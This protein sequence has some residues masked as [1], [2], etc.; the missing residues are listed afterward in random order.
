VTRLV[1]GKALR[2][3]A[4]LFIVSF[5]LA[6]LLDLAP[7]DPAVSLLGDEAT[8]AQ[9]DK[10]HEDLRLD[11]PFYTR[12]WDWISDVVRGDFGTSY[13]TKEHVTTMILDRIPV[14]LE[15]VTL[16][17]LLALAIAIPVG[18]YTAYRADGRFDRGW[19]L[20]SSGMISI[21]PFVTALVLVYVFAL[22][23][24]DS[25]LRLPATG[26]A[27][28]GDSVPN[29]LW[30]VT[31]PVVTLAVVEIPAFSRLLRAD[32]IATLQE[33]YILAARAKGV[34][35]RR[36]L[37]RHALRPSSFSL[38]TLAGLS[39]ARLIGGAVVV[40]TLFAVPGLGQLII[41]AVYDRDILVLQGVVMFI[42]IVY[43]VVN[44]LL[45][46]MYVWLDPRARAGGLQP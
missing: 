16:A 31:L 40:E 8:P 45:D 43:I 9:M 4:V 24:R 41:R 11:E 23:L 17:V 32:M 3:V 6:F 13:R 25:P 35:T 22:L 37:L 15:I 46:I 18:I 36:I 26:W 19:L 5:A 38:V 2:V 27:D 28:L 44:T 29:N 10:V 14:T 1:L 7:G 21:P 12:Y 20:A 30:Y 33:D 39:V 42:A 34:P